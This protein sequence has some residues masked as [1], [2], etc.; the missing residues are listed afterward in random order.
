MSAAGMYIEFCGSRESEG[1]R[2]TH[3]Y[4]LTD[5]CWTQEIGRAHLAAD[6]GIEHQS[7]AKLCNNSWLGDL[8]TD[9]SQET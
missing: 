7:I 8:R 9:T 1:S 6:R 5:T 4:Q 2:P 3:L